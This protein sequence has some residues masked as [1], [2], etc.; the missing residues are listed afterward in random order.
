[1]TFSIDID[2]VDFDLARCVSSGQVFRWR[3]GPEER[4][5]GQDGADAFAVR[6]EDG[7]RLAVESTADEAVFRNHYLRMEGRLSFWRKLIRSLEK[8]V[9]RAKESAKGLL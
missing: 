8:R 7:G 2:P 1:L 9:H 6:I 3:M 4:W 5:L